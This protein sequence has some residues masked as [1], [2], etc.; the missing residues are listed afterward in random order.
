M[1][2]GIALLLSQSATAE[3][4]RWVDD[5]GRQHFTQSLEDVPPAQRESAR[6]A[7]EK[8]PRLNA[9]DAPEAPPAR[10]RSRS[11]RTPREKLVCTGGGWCARP[12]VIERRRTPTRASE[13][14]GLVGGKS[15]ERWGREHQQL[16]DRISQLEQEIQTLEFAR[17][18]E[19]PSPRRENMSDHRFE[20]KQ[21]RHRRYV[22]AQ[23]ELSRARQSLRALVDRARR[24]GVPNHWLY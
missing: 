8:R 7:A 23:N 15:Q 20:R 14:S 19:Y 18:D 11:L 4:Y 5:Q 16:L 10:S 6:A 13:S 24:E 2:L 22:Q 1:A 21:R 17:A 3:I 12:G 9:V